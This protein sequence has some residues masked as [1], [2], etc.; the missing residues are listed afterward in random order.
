MKRIAIILSILSGTTA[1]LAETCDE[2]EVLALN[3][4]H[5]ARGEGTDHMQMVGEVTLNRTWHEAYPND[6]CSVVYQKSQF[7]WTSQIKDPTPYEQEVWEVALELAE[8]LLNGDIDYFDNG[9]THFLNPDKL[10][11]LPMWAQ[12]FEKVGKLGN[13]V[14][15]RM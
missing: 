13:H 10:S 12:K 8:N 4:Y 6:V 15:Y 14:F 3:M 9:A 5:E 7:S 11:R 2:V 1:A